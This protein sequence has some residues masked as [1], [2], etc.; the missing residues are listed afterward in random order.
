MILRGL[1]VGPFLS[2]CYIVG[3]EITKEGMVIDPGDEAR[4]ILKNAQELGLTIKL[5]VATHGHIDH[6]GALKQVKEATNAEFAIHEAEADSFQGQS[7][8]VASL[9][10]VEYDPAPP[11]DRLLNEGD[12]IEVGDLKFQ[13]LHTPG[14][15]PGGIS[16]VGH[17]VVF[18]G[19][20]LFNFSIGRTDF[21]GCSYEQLINSIQG[22][23]M[24]LPDETKVFPGH[25]PETT[26][27]LER[28]HNP[29]LRGFSPFDF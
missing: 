2:N 6:I 15:S 27:G 24:V 1:E 19:D 8:F 23:L 25:G 9:F 10:G 29:F 3:S 20:S 17:G 4:G 5:I 26:I 12:T 21:P 13:V 7:Q 18:S 22:K 28:K 16:L 14:H 11:P